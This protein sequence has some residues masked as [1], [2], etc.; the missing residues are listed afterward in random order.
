MVIAPLGHLLKRG[1]P[2]HS[3]FIMGMDYQ[4]MAAN[5]QVNIVTKS[6][7]LNERFGDTDSLRI[8][9]SDNCCFRNYNVITTVAIVKYIFS[10]NVSP[11]PRG[12]RRGTR[13]G[14]KALLAAPLKG[15][16][17]MSFSP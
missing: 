12:R 10:A 15:N 7:L 16:T 6:A 17:S 3:G 14:W 13:V 4:L 8:A 2:S 11:Q 5:I 1:F 9:Y